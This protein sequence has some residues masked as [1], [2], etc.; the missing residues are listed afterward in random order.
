MTKAIKTEGNMSKLWQG[1]KQYLKQ[2]KEH[3]TVMNW[4]Y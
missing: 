2:K 3:L 4:N 1:L